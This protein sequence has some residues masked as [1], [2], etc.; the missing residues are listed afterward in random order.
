MDADYVIAGGGSAGCVLASR[1]SADPTVRVLLL[2]A[3]GDDLHPAVYIPAGSTQLVGK[4]RW[5]WVWRCEPDPSRGNRVDIWPGGRVLGGGSS[6]NGMVYLRGH[7]SDYDGWAALGNPGWRYEDVLPSFVRAEGNAGRADR[8]HGTDGPLGVSDV[9]CLHPTDRAFVESGVNAG[10]RRNPDFNGAEQEGVGFLQATQRG[11]FRASTARGY[12]RPVRRRP[13]LT[14]VT[15]ALATRVTIEGGRATGVAYLRDGAV[16]H[17]R[18][19]REVL[20]STGTII[21]P[22]LLLLSGIG[23]RSALAAL[24]IDCIVERPAVGANLQEHPGVLMSWNVNVPTMNADWHSWRGRLRAALDYALFRRGP[25]SSPVAH[26]ALFLKTRPELPAPDIQVHFQPLSY[27]VGPDGFGL[28]EA[29]RVSCAVNVCRP[30][31]RGMIGLRS[32]DPLA[33][34]LIRHALLG[35]EADV[36]TL[37][38]GCRKVRDVFAS[39]PLRAMVTGEHEPGP[40]V[41]DDAQWDAALRE[42]SFPMY[43]PVGTCRMGSD[44]EAVVDPTLRVRGVSGLRVVDASIMPLLVAANTNAAAVMIGERGAELI[45]RGA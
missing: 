3:G 31:A 21:S 28:P 16:L 6:V 25:A 13:N 32:A 33:P 39:E 40:G 34:P 19:R 36:R 23:A 15:G 20:L 10:H 24:G 18:A 5:D 8:F 2:E 7:R 45:L 4:P 44:D 29:W 37:V 30:R 12:L 35:D 43:H 1:L 42:R 17:A 27:E 11:G 14:V 26:A 22:K 9:R 38:A 41:Q